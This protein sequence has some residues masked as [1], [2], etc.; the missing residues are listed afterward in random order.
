MSKKLS[1]SISSKLIFLIVSMSLLTLC[2]VSVFN[3]YTSDKILKQRV[4][5]QLISE[6]TSRGTAIVSLIETRIQQITL[7]S[8]NQNI[9]DAVK[10]SS[11]N[12]S[13]DMLKS[14][15]VSFDEAMGESIGLDN[16]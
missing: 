11:A 8:T 2:G 16:I 14:E 3:F 1:L 5:D 6:S 13:L 9:R 15:V 4:E 12:Q 10:N 7:L